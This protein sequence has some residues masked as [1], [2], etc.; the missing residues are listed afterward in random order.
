MRPRLYNIAHSS[1]FSQMD[2]AAN[3]DSLE[4]VPGIMPRECG[5]RRYRIPVSTADA[6][7]RVFRPV[8]LARHLFMLTAASISTV[9][10]RGTFCR[11]GGASQNVSYR[12]DRIG[13]RCRLG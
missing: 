2:I 9:R 12:A 13:N 7:L 5:S 10:G 3:L 11:K 4:E 8:L 1:R 6:I